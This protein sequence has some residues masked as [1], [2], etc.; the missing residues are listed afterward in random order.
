MFAT[1]SI[2]EIKKLFAT[3]KFIFTCD[4][5][6]CWC[7]CNMCWIWEN[8]IYKKCLPTAFSCS[9]HFVL[10]VGDAMCFFCKRKKSFNL[11]RLKF[12]GQTRT[13]KWTKQ[14]LIG[15]RRVKPFTLLNVGQEDSNVCNS[16]IFTTWYNLRA[17]S[18]HNAQQF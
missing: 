13:F 6:V 14:A 5:L 17:H 11:E 12:W 4:V 7:M 10:N 9:S 1:Y 8:L 18:Q 15:R 3:D 16:L 2:F